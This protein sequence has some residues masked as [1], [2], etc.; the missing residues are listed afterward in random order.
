MGFGGV[1]RLRGGAG[2]PYIPFH[3]V[4]QT[5]AAVGFFNNIRTPAALLSGAA[6]G[7]V[8]AMQNLDETTFGVSYWKRLRTAYTT[9]MVIS[10]TTEILTVLMSTGASNR[11]LAGGFNPMA[12]SCIAM[13]S[14]EFEFDLVAVQ[15]NFMTGMVA[16]VA[17]QAIRFYKELQLKKHTKHISRAAAWLLAF[18]VLEMIAFFNHRLIVFEGYPQLTARY[19]VLMWHRIDTIVEVVNRPAAVFALGC[20]LVACYHIC[21]SLLDANQDGQLDEND[22]QDWQVYVMRKMGV[23][24]KAETL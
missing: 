13:I 23:K 8:F 15:F 11:A 14:R 10:F 9:L 21:L 17:A 19:L 6:L 5:N 22:F 1:T 7:Q 20:V 3:I 4:D 12:E 24:M 2:Q 18:A 16:F